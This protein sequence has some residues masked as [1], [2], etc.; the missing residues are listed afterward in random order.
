[1]RTILRFECAFDDYTDNAPDEQRRTRRRACAKV[2]EA[3]ICDV[4]EL[5]SA[6]LYG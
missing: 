1:M 4:V 2:Q 5:I 6:S 3:G